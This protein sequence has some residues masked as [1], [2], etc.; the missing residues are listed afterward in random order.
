MLNIVKYGDSIN[1]YIYVHAIA[2]SPPEWRGDF[3]VQDFGF[4]KLGGGRV[5][6]KDS[7]RIDFMRRTVV[8]NHANP[9]LF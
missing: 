7:G 4:S 1:Y 6:M 3:K 2:S 9:F 5:P 8:S